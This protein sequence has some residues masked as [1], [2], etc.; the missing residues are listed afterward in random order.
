MVGGGPAGAVAAFQLAKAG[1][2][3]LLIDRATFPRDKTCGESL[4]PGAIERLRVMGMWQPHLP[5]HLNSSDRSRSQ[6][7]D[8]M[9]VSSPKGTTFHG[10]YRRSTH[11]MGL[12]IRRKE[13]DAELLNAAIGKGVRVLE[14]TEAF[15][16]DGGPDQ[17]AIVH[18]RAGRRGTSLSI[19]A[20]R[21]IVADGRR[22]FLARKL[23]F[24]EASPSGAHS[25]PKRYAVR[26]HCQGVDGL[27]SLA[28]M[29]V[30][31]G[32]YC[33]IAPL[34]SSAANVC[35]VLFA[36][37]IQ[38]NPRTMEA[39]FRRDIGAFPE[40]AARLRQ[41]HIDGPIQVVGP[42]RLQSKRQSR[43]SFIACGD[44]T[45]FLDPFTGEGIAHAIASGSLGSEAVLKSL[46][47]DHSA[48]SAYERKI[49]ALRRVKGG[50]AL[51]LFGLVTH[52]NLANSVATVF[53]R[54]PSLGNLAVQLFG[55][56]V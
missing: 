11:G 13:L 17:T 52:P 40:S 54:L 26:A 29:H 30:G 21:V 32:G 47:G 1:V 14:G 55:D 23:G 27:S 7:I 20:R 48:F 42:L 43:E 5:D 33:G 22:S 2:D 49:R 56:Q 37:R 6:A 24:L 31:R 44:T 34:S 4:S 12:G 18:A 36:D 45:G 28:E 19:H 16:G 35:Y 3:V 50:A 38:M 25:G 10:M 39:D 9:R 51:A 15:D 41:A 46:Q 53:A 8:G